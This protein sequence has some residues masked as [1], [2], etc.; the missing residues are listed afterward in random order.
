MKR[1]AVFDIGTNS[2]LL[3]VA[4]KRQDGTVR[5]LFEAME[6]PRLGAGLQAAGRIGAGAVKR[7]I[8]SLKLL[9][10]RARQYRPEKTFA[11]GTNVFRQAKNR[12]AVVRQIAEHTGIEIQVISGKS[13]AALAYAGALSGLKGGKGNAVVLDIGGGSTELALRTSGKFWLRSLP[14]GAVRLTEKFG[15][16]SRPLNKLLEQYRKSIQTILARLRLPGNRATLV[17][18]GGT[19]TTLGALARGLRKYDGRE[20]HGVKLSRRAVDQWLKKL[21]SRSLSER[22]R[23]LSFEPARADIIVAGVA[24]LSAI[25]HHFDFAKVVVSD[26]GLRW[27]V[28]REFFRSRGFSLESYRPTSAAC[29]AVTCC[30]RLTGSSLSRSKPSRAQGRARLPSDLAFC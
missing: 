28:A 15:K 7:T 2:I 22:R 27:G 25:M 14:I 1:I 3:L 26:H 29:E 9:K 18:T 8:Q 11:I 12:K 5:V 17:G 4:G 16:V 10:K 24:I 21:S 19:L 20:V 30:Y 23:L 6:T 13:E